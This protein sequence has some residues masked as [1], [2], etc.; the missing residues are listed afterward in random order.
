[1]RRAFGRL[2]GGTQPP[3]EPFASA[4]EVTARIGEE[5]LDHGGLHA[6]LLVLVIVIVIVIVAIGQ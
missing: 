5:F 4:A 6:A 1:L 2:A 3:E